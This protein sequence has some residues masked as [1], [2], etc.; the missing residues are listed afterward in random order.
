MIIRPCQPADAEVL[1]RVFTK[2]TPTA[3]GT[4][5]INDYADFLQT[6]TDP[7]FVVE[8][9]GG[10][11]GA[12]GYYIRPDGKTARIVWIFA[13]PDAKGLRVGSALLTHCL[14]LIRQQPEIDL[15]ECQTSQVAYQF[16][17]RFGFQLQGIQPDYWTPG[18]DLYF[19]TATP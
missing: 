2:N 1:V 5:E 17:K 9:D 4:N 3:F 19:M 15:I 13:D 18:L 10:L 6:N 12:C 11:I 16:F 8:H 14:N 7:Y